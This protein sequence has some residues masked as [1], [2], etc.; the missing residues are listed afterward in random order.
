MSI[1]SDALSERKV[2]ALPDLYPEFVTVTC[3]STLGLA[4]SLLFTS[5]LSE[6][7]SLIFAGG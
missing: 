6:V 3:F 1:L 5:P 4:V 2:N 7:T